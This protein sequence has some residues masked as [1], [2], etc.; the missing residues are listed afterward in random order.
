VIFDNTFRNNEQ[1]VDFQIEAVDFDQGEGVQ[2]RLETDQL[3]DWHKPSA[4]WDVTILE[5]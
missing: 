1:V 2:I 3:R 5:D 4:K